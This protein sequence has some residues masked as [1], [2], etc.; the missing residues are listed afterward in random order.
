VREPV[1][2]VDD[3]A[4]ENLQFIRHA[5]ERSTTF[6]AV[7]GVGGALMGAVGLAVTVIAALQPTAEMWLASWLS[8][9]VI[10]LTIG[11]VAIRAKATRLGLALAGP[12][13]R[14]FALGLSA[15]FLAGA[16]LTFGLWRHG[17]WALVPPTWLLLYGTGVL[18]GG[19]FSVAP[20]RVLGLAFMTLGV[21]ALVTPAAWGDLWLGLGFGALQIVFGVHVARRYGG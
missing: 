12:P 21:A 19:A 13:A 20:M 9:A 14:R 4:A 15:P 1:A 8:A 6:S 5:M 2:S 16:A 11:L 7:P 3:H 18:M 17:V 10:A